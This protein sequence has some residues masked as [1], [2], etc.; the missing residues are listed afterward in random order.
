MQTCRGD[1]LVAGKLDGDRDF[2]RL[3]RLE[4]AVG[5]AEEEQ[6]QPDDEDEEEEHGTP[7]SVL[8]DGGPLVPSGGFVALN[9]KDGR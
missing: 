2:C 7:E 1:H 6:W 9:E 4:D 8:D 5:H 3:V